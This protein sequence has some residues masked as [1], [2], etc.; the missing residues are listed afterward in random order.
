MVDNS[1]VPSVP[2]VGVPHHT[3]T[4]QGNDALTALNCLFYISLAIE[5]QFMVVP[6][7]QQTTSLAMGEK[8][9]VFQQ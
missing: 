5:L 2:S 1:T 3:I 7:V 6:L 8:E 9:K 4:V